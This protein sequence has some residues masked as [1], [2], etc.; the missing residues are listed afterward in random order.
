MLDYISTRGNAPRLD[1]TGVTLAGLAEDGGLYVPS[2]C[3]KISAEEI[4]NMASQQYLEI[5]WRVMLPFVEGS[6]TS[7]ELMGILR[8]AYK[9]FSHKEIAP[10]HKF[11]DHFYLLELF[12]G[13]T[14][15]FKDVALQ[16]LGQVFD[17]ILKN[18]QQRVT[19]V[20]ATSG[21]TGSAAIEAFQGK[22]NAD[23]FILHPKGRVS[24]V[25]RRQ[26]TTVQAVN[27]HNIA[28]EGSF[29]DCQDIVKAM[30]ND[31]KFRADTHLSAV[32]SINWA[33]ILAQVVYYIYAGA[34]IGKPVVFCVPT[35]NFGNVYAGYVA[36]SM[37]LPVERLVVA[38]NKNDILYRFFATGRMKMEGVSPTLSPSMDIQVS[39]NFERVLFDVFGR[40]GQAVGQTM[41][42]FREKG[43]FHLEEHSMQDLRKVFASGRMDDAETLA[44][45]RR[46]Y[47]QHN[48]I[49]D[50]HTA[51]GVGVAEKYREKYKDSVIVSLA[52]AHPAKFPAAVKE[53]IGIEPELPEPLADLYERKERCETLP[54]DAE[55]VKAFVRAN[56]TG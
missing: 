25:Q 45:M 16:F 52:T 22:H 1:F 33:R 26:M 18:N 15:A 48:Y 38:T 5:A 56:V 7:A 50:P 19:I 12:H 23:I 10:L 42:H 9:N 24:E 6:L 55:K 54:A 47:K 53:A 30:F 11:D 28:I 4:A 34:R 39:S 21:D 46:F 44:V 8:A 3:P 29:D 17:H 40:Q 36:Q 43:P 2:A 14:L 37:G 31:V 27:V 20:G 35:G 41:Q 51:V 13:P 32:N 49:L